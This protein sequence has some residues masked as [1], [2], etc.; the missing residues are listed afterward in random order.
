MTITSSSRLLINENPLQ[1]LPSLA[2]ALKN[3]NEAIMLQQVQYWLSRSTKAFEGRKWVYNTIDD[4]KMQ[5]PWMTEKTIRNR[6]SSLIEKKVII[7]SNFNR[8]GFD[9]TKWYT[10]DY[11]KLNS[12]VNDQ[13]NI[14]NS[15][16][17][18][19][20][21]HSEKSSG[22]K[23]KKVPNATGKSYRT[24]TRDYQRLLR[25]YTREYSF[26]C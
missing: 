24:Y 4:W 12:L 20:M 18:P 13:D 3:V 5:F 8:A 21:T 9:R 10:I 25:D 23:W 16:E 14:E 1:V 26:I 15:A 7:T 17:K 22:S 11:D 19:D 2:V 6:F